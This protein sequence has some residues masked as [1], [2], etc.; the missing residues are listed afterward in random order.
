MHLVAALVP[1]GTHLGAWRHPDAWGDTVINRVQLLEV[2]HIAQAAKFDCVFLADGNAVRDMDDR[3]L[4]E[5]MSPAARPAGFEPITLLASIAAETRH[6]GLAATA[7]TSFDEPFALARRFASLDHLSDGRAAWN[8]VTSSFDGD[9]RNFSRVAHL[10]KEERYARAREFADV[11]FGLWDSWAEDAFPQDRGNAQYLDADKVRVL[12]HVGPYFQVRGPLNI[13]R[14]PQG[15]PVVF[16]AGQSEAGRALA[17]HA[18]DCVFAMTPTKAAAIAHSRDM[19]D[20]AEALG[21]PRES[22]RVIPGMS[23]YI[24]R[25]AAEAEER[26]AELNALIP[27]ALGIGHLSKILYTDLSRYEVDAPMPLLPAPV[28]GVSAMRGI[29]N[30]MVAAEAPTIRQVYERFLPSLGHPIFKG[31]PIDIADQ[32]EDWITSGACDGF[33]VIP[34]IM[35]TMLRLFADAVVP[36]LQRRGLFRRDYPAGTLRD[37]MGLA[38]PVRA[39]G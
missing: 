16:H 18:A 6:I 22:L 35:P 28:S 38:T 23:L 11:T 33:L 5:A 10:P 36:E 21:R 37:V 19:K 32:I 14:P 26:L 29:V 20:R 39:A 27:P 4:F 3:A 24:G 30:D 17:A 15:R 31:G 25:S 13:A 9:A 34:A 1:I 8:L 12:D 2:A 7:T